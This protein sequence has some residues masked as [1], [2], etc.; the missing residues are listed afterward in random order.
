MRSR[1]SSVWAQRGDGRC[2]EGEPTKCAAGEAMFHDK[3]N[4]RLQAAAIATYEKGEPNRGR[5]RDGPS[6]CIHVAACVKAHAHAEDCG[7]GSILLLGCLCPKSLIITLMS[8]GQHVHSHS[9]VLAHFAH[10]CTLRTHTAK[11]S[12]SLSHAENTQTCTHLEALIFLNNHIPICL[13]VCRLLKMQNKGTRTACASLAGQTHVRPGT[14]ARMTHT[15]ACTCMR[16]CTCEHTYACTHAHAACAHLLG[17]S[18]GANTRATS[19]HKGSSG[20]VRPGSDG[21]GC[22]PAQACT[23]S[24]GRRS[25][26]ASCAGFPPAM[27]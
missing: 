20:P 18:S 7:V 13:S 10:V 11:F 14:H 2:K 17:C 6:T 16:T 25:Q 21:C 22:Q 15:C 12:Y 24:S 26:G 1:E 19:R 8:H 4:Q 23:P 27:A 9:C 3:H 5:E